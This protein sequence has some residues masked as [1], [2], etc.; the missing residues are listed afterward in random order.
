MTDSDDHKSFKSN[1]IELFGKT[2]EATHKHTKNV[3]NSFFVFLGF[4]KYYTIK[5]YDIFRPLFENQIWQVLCIL[6]CIFFV[7]ACLTSV[8]E[9]STHN[10][11]FYEVLS[12]NANDV[13]SSVIF[14]AVWGIGIGLFINIIFIILISL[15]KCL[16]QCFGTI[17]DKINDEIPEIEEI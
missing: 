11:I 15:I 5:S 12:K 2:Y 1:T 9:A 16:Y 10:K 14:G 13:M 8:V 7:I 3:N 6:L 4:I 17:K